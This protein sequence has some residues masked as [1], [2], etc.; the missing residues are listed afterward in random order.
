MGLLQKIYKLE[1][2]NKDTTDELIK[3]NKGSAKNPKSNQE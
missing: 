1:V 2:Q 3:N